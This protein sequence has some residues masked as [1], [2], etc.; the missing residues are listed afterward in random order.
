MSLVLKMR[1]SVTLLA[2]VLMIILDQINWCE[3]HDFF[4][5]GDKFKKHLFHVLYKHKKYLK[6]K[7][8][9]VGAAA[10]AAASSHKKIPVPFPLPIP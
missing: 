5:H 9:V 2:L 3:S 10:L 6:N 7:G 8:L 1:L 4:D